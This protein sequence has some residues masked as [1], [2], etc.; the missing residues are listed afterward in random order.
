M[1][2]RFFTVL[3]IPEKTSRVRRILVP[4]WVVKGSFVGVIFAGALTAMMLLDYWYVMNQIGENKDLKIQNRRLTQ[5]IQIYKNRMETLENTMERVERFSTRL[6]VITNIG[7]S[8]T[9]LQSLNGPLPEASTNIGGTSGDETF[10][11]VGGPLLSDIPDQD[12]EKKYLLQ[13]QAKIDES[14]NE[15][16]H[17]SLLVE[18]NLQ[19]LYELLLDQ[20]AFLAALPTRKPAFGYYTSGFGVRKSPF[21]GNIKMHEGLDIANHPGTP[22]RAPANGFVVFA[23]RKPGY[24]RTVIVDHGYGLETWYG[25]AAKILVKVGDKIARGNQIALMGTTGRSTA[26]HVHYEVRVHGIPVDPLSY[27]LEE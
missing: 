2:N 8:E 23:G 13:E 1:A 12:P 4:N 16:H 22:I 17:Q 19:D 26:P 5:Q 6:R 15:L 24:G 11:G 27:I 25:H 7:D 18:Q 9:L 21:G 10:T 14:F 3:V 20:K